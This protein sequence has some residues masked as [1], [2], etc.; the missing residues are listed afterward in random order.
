MKVAATQS[1]GTTHRPNLEHEWVT[2]DVD[3]LAGEL[4]GRHAGGRRGERLCRHVLE[5]GLERG[6]ELGRGR[7]E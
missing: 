7:G 1:W 3:R 5:V 2:V 6:P 4:T